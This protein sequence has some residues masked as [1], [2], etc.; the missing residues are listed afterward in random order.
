MGRTGK[1]LNGNRKGG[2]Q[3]GGEVLYLF[4]V[5]VDQSDGH[6]LKDAVVGEKREHLLTVARFLA[7]LRMTG[8]DGCDGNPLSR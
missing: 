1:E 2:L 6:V 3:A 7:A 5:T 4:F 8:G